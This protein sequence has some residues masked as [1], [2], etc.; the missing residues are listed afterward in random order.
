MTSENWRTAW[1]LY[2]SAREL[3]AA[4]R[5][6]LL[7]SIDTDPEVLQEVASLLDEPEEQPPETEGDVK[8]P[9]TSFGMGRYTVVE[10]LG[11]GGMSEVYSARDQQLGR[12]VA[13]KFLRPGTIGVR[14]AERVM[15]EAKTLSGLNHPNIVTVYEVIQSDAGLA[16][17]MELV[18]GTA[19]RSLCGTPLPEEQVLHLGQQIAQALA[20]AHA[21]GIVHR[22][23]KPENILLRP[24][25]YVKVVDFGLARQ[26]A[27]DDLTSIHGLTMGTLR[28]MS[29]EQVRGEAVSPASDV[30]SLGL[31]LYELAIGEHPFTADSSVQTAYS[32]ATKRAAPLPHTKDRAISS[33]LEQLI[34]AMLAK[35]PAE[36]PAAADVTKEL[37]KILLLSGKPATVVAGS[38]KRRFW[39][40]ALVVCFVG[41]TAAAWLMLGRRD[42]PELGE[43]KIEPLTSQGGWELA[44]AISPDGQS[45][46][47]TWSDKLDGTKNIYVKRLA[48]DNPVRLTNN[49]D[50]LIGYLAWSPDGKRIAFKYA[51]KG[52][53][54]FGGSIYS[55]P[56]G[57]GRAERLFD[58]VN[59]DLSSGIDWSPDGTELAFSDVLPG[60]SRLALYLLNLRTGKTRRLTSPAVE[61]WGDWNPKFSPDGLTIAF[62]RVTGFWLDDLYLVTRRGGAPRRLTATQRGI[63]GHAWWPDGKSLIVSCQRTGSIFGIWRFPLTPNLPPE[64]ISLGGMDAI[65]P[66]VSRKI[67]RIAWVDQLWD[68]NIYQIA[69]TGAGTPVKLI[70]STLR[71]QGATYSPDG[72]IAFVSD[73]SGSREIWL[74]NRD[75]SGQLRVTNLKGPPIDH[76]QWSPDGRQI[77]FESRLPGHIGLF[78]LQ[79]NVGSLSCSGPK[80]LTSQ[81]APEAA[82]A[83]S[84]DG[85]FLYFASSRTGQWEVWKQPAS[86]GQLAQVTRDG[87]FISHESMDSKWLYFSKHDIE[88]IYRQPLVTSDRQ[89][90]ASAELV[91]GPPY[92]VQPGGWSLTHKEIIFIDRAT[93]DHP[94]VIRAYNPE[95][96]AMRSILSLN[97]LFADR[98][99]IGLSVSPDEKWIL[100]SQLDRSGSNVM[101]AE[102]R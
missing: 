45:V 89:A 7:D 8:A 93:R 53:G 65:T 21:H 29:P 56:A 38:R 77:A 36:R 50:G 25:G 43:L 18:E 86:G 85:K 28:Y 3:P 61:D 100:Y 97:E 82:P 26:V 76:L 16:I 54:K 49:S 98:P 72:R 99:D 32:I 78:A 46:A 35:D 6:I 19:L 23:I 88:A 11:K 55:I 70:A 20:A 14:S 59:A 15:C 47:F 62:K 95:T 10:Y 39:L 87:G 102:S 37:G 66:T 4:E 69:A 44:P 75:G 52:Y 84:P 24:D 73:R 40:V 90:A 41:I 74:A 22:D 68:L 63:W 42:A 60:A 31:V 57:G 80:R 96:K 34:F 13:L 33:H 2:N 92:R 1:E 58:L 94:A 30:F 79:C 81:S 71:D 27:A 48:E 12:I 64:R 67:N 51:G 91:I 101:L 17:V 9:L 5:A 83:W